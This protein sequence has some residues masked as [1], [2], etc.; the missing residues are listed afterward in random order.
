MRLLIDTDAFCK[1]GVGSLLVDAVGLLGADLRGC[2]RLPA[3][4]HMLRRGKV[5]KL[6]GV[7]ACEA[8]VPIAESMPVIEPAS[9]VWLDK[10]TSVQ[11]I[12]PGEA[13][14][15][16]SAA[17]R[18]LIVITGDKRA[19]RSLRSIPSFADALAGRIVVLDAL[20]IALCDH[21]GVEELRRRIPALAAAD[22]TAKV[23]F[24]VGNA[25][26]RG[27]L[28][29]YHGSLIVELDPL[30]LWAPCPGSTV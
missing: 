10:L 15:F 28:L 6:F 19:L 5:P 4:P 2:G 25:D 14:M 20:L 9:D 8:L 18:S 30:Q 17:E 21:L 13:Q 3:L 16:A 29:S 23:C 1:L 12:D 24:S 7:E 11:G 22:K 26:P 27:A